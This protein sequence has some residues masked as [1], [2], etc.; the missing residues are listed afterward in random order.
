MKIEFKIEYD[1]SEFIRGYNRRD[2]VKSGA[3]PRFEELSAEQ[4]NL[5][6]S[7]MDS[8]TADIFREAYKLVTA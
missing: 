4:I 1:Y 7:D 8:V 2:A 5:M 6:T 3:E